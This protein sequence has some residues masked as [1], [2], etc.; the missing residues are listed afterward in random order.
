MLIMAIKAGFEITGKINRQI[1][2]SPKFLYAS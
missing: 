2:A 1:L